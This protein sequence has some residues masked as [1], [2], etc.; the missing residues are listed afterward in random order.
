[1]ISEG[2]CDTEEW[3]NDAENSALITEINYIL[4]HIHIE[5]SPIKLQN[6]SQYYCNEATER[7]ADPYAKFLLKDV[8]KNRH[9]SDNGK[10]VCWRQDKE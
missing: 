2:S 6:I 9:G 7:H 4:Q 8:V 10:Q 5:N 3:S 1:M